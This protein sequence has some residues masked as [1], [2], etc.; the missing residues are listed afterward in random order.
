MEL[1]RS[2][3]VETDMDKMK[4]PDNESA[5]EP[6]P[7][8]KEASNDI[9][10]ILLVD[11]EPRNLDVL[12]SILASPELNLIRAKTAEDALLALM[13]HEFACIILDVQ[14]PSM[15][16]LELARLIKTRKRSQ[17]IPIIFLT[18]Y[19]LEDKDI[20]QGYGVGAVD[21]LTK[22]INPQILK[23]KVGVFVDL[24]QKNC[25][26][27]GVNNA[28]EQEMSQRKK[29]EEALKHANNELESRVRERT[30]ELMS[31]RDELM[32]ASRA[33]DGFLATLSHELRT[34]LNPVLLIASDAA[35]NHD[36]PPGARTDFDTIRRNIELEARLI[37]D[38]LDLTRITRGKI[39]LDRHFLHIRRVL[40]EAIEHV[41][42]E[43]HQKQI[44]L[45]MNLGASQHIIYADA[46]RMQQIFWNLL[47][48]AVKF[49][50]DGGQIT[51]EADVKEN[52]IAIKI[53]DTG[54]G[55]TPEETSRIFNAFSQG[56]HAANGNA[57]QFGGLGLG[58]AISQK[59]AA[60]HY[61]R[62]IAASEGRHRG[63]TFTVEL[64]LAQAA[65]KKEGG[66]VSREPEP[67]PKLPT[68]AN[69]IIV[70]LVEDHEPTRT[71]LTQLLMRRSYKVI[72]AASIAEARNLAAVETF[73]LVI[74]DIGLPDGD[75]YELMAELQKVPGVKGIALTGYGMEQDLARSRRAGFM[76]HLTKPVAIQSLEAALNAA[77]RDADFNNEAK[78]SSSSEVT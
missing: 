7:A 30:A 65:D 57:H 43:I 52:K 58:L 49:T 45:K 69:G 10:N 39:S 17:H 15:S 66:I 61:G 21:Y 12:D 59:L 62:I 22:P 26:L 24:F 31:I 74:S 78:R 41:R 56:E 46:V 51:I 33:K 55:M 77:V 42:E 76:A 9:V 32:A 75:G 73:N 50:P 11:D 3:I 16:G 54:I 38:L 44:S 34:P 14:M 40:E 8:V 60:L 29:A 27:I 28:L 37:D 13:H 68:K 48:N 25:A 4:A 53:T 23:S 71:A 35:N 67:S 20:L 1:C 18:A 70:L 6:K 47:K 5:I 19:F 2:Q 72:S 64:P 36:L 63:S